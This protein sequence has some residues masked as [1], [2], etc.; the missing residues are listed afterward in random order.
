M[1]PGRRLR[2]PPAAHRYNLKARCSH[3]ESN[4]LR[5][6]AILCVTKPVS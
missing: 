3:K 2:R 6:E 5:A 1:A 4:L